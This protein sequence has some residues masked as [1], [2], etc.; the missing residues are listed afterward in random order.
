MFNSLSFHQRT[1]HNNATSYTPIPL[2][3]FSPWSGKNMQ[4][5]GPPRGTVPSH[6]IPVNSHVHKYI[7]FFKITCIIISTCN[8]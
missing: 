3:G 1:S 2:Q 8:Y 7:S 5:A 4:E 6:V